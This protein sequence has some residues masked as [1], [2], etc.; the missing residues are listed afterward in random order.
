MKKLN[1]SQELSLLKKLERNDFN[2]NINRYADTS[3]PPENF[4]VKGILMVEF[5]LKKFKMIIY[6]KF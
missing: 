4:D 3:P 5:Q 6:K 1:A 2:L